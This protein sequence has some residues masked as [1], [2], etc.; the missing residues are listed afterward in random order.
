MMNNCKAGRARPPS[1]PRLAVTSLALSLGILLFALPL[2][3]S[4]TPLTA[5]EPI[6]FTRIRPKYRETASFKRISE[7]FTGKENPGRN[8]IFR[9]Q[10]ENRD[11]FYFAFRV[12]APKGAKVPAGTVALLVYLPNATEPTE[13]TYD[14]EAQKKRWVPVMIGLTGSDWA[15]PE[16]NPVAWRLEYRT[17]TG[18]ITAFANSF[19]WALPDED[20]DEETD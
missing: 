9:T 17:P 7:F 3:L 4:A 10:P 2:L 19:L 13:Y 8:I 12:E 11:G 5:A 6:D 18:E 16:A 15:D 14:L 20:E 1:A